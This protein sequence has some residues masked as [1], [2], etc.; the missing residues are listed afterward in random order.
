MKT[1]ILILKTK[2]NDPSPSFSLLLLYSR[3]MRIILQL[4]QQ[5][6]YS[7]GSVRLPIRNPVWGSGWKE[8]RFS[9]FPAHPS[10]TWHTDNSSPCRGLKLSA[11]SSWTLQ[12]GVHR[13]RSLDLTTPQMYLKKIIGTHHLLDFSL[14]QDS[15][16]FASQCELLLK[17]VCLVP[18]L[19]TEKILLQPCLGI[20]VDSMLP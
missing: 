1:A 4:P 6:H 19:S 9:C 13:I 15:G 17:A 2:H 8:L 12:K 10:H 16:L 11:V 14:P 18:E 7:K 5:C 20:C 3:I